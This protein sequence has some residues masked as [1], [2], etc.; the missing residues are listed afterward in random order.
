M[1]DAVVPPPEVALGAPR[2][3]GGLVSLWRVALALFALCLG[4]QA[5]FGRLDG[6]WW[7]APLPPAALP[8]AVAWCGLALALAAGIAARPVTLPLALCVLLA[9]EPA[10]AGRGHGLLIGLLV[11]AGS[12]SGAPYGSWPA[13]GRVDP[14]GGWT[15]P[16]GVRGLAWVGLGATWLYTAWSLAEAPGLGQGGAV[17]AI[18]AYL[19]GSVAQAAPWPVAVEVLIFGVAAAFVPLSLGARSR[20]MAWTAGVAV[21]ALTLPAIG[22]PG[23]SVGVLLLHALA[24]DPRWVPAAGQA[25]GVVYYDGACGL[26]HNAI[27]FLLAEDNAGELRFA[28]L[29][30]ATFAARVPAHVDVPDSVIV[31]TDD[32]ELLWKMAAAR[33]L[34]ARLGGGWRVI[35][36]LV[37]LVPLPVGDVVYDGIARVRHRLFARPKDSCPLLP[38]GLRA[39]F[40][41]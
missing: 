17:A 1:T 20:P 36:W 7:P 32:G 30:G 29:Q 26:C 3:T 21:H 41:P 37:R 23:F 19:R 12:M 22:A 13:R 31:Q 5:L 24:F 15:L 35:G 14:G 39:R 4:V 10:I 33:H 9:G 6:S 34:L 27:R 11:L 16:G 2:W 40:L 8:A 18:A 38:P 25:V 28:A